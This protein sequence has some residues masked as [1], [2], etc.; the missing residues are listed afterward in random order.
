[1]IGAAGVGKTANF[2]YPNLEYACASG[3]S[4]ITTDTKGDLYRNYGCI[5]KDYYGYDVSV[6]DLRNPTRSDGNNMLHLVN[7]YMDEYLANPDNLSAKARAEKYAKII[8][9]TIVNSGGLDAGSY[10][11]NAFF[12]DAAE[13]LLTA[14]ILLVAEY[15]PKE[16]RHIISVFKLIQDLLAPSGKRKSSNGIL[17]MKIWKNRNH[18]PHQIKA[19]CLLHL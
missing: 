2:L 3:M 10:G 11:Q 19:A 14:V 15:C 6:I 8:A 12:Y 9:K 4:F 16:K 5:A 18:T 7:K 1:M 13:G 17:H